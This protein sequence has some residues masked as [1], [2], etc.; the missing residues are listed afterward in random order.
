[1]A[2][3]VIGKRISSFTDKKT[4]EVITFGKIFVV[5]PAGEDMKGAEGEIAEAISVKPELASQIPIDSEI[6]LYYN[7]YGK[8]HAF[9]LA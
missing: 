7:K 9:D 4:G 6:E 8:V 3:K 5:Y 1:M 2:V